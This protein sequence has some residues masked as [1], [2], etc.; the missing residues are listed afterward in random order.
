[1]TQQNNAEPLQKT[2][3]IA[4]VGRPNV[5]KSTLLN[6]LIGQKIS[7]VSRKAQ[8]TRHAITGILTQDE[9]QFIFVDTP[10]FQTHHRNALNQAMNRS[11]EQTLQSVDLVLF[12][13]EA[14]RFTD[15]DR[16]VLERISSQS[17]VILVINKLDHVDDK[18]KLLPFLEKMNGEF[19]FVA[20]VPISA[21]GGTNLDSL[22]EAA[23]QCL[24][25]TPWIFAEDE[26]TDKNE[27]FLA[28]EFIREK[29]FRLMGDEIPYGAT[30]EIEKFEEQGT[31]RRIF[32]AIIVAREN[33]KAMIIGQGGERLK[34]I[35]SE[36]RIEM[37]K[38]FGSKIYL[39][40]WVKVKSGWADDVRALKSLGYD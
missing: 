17:K 31:L 7:I 12:V 27:R 37:E 33:H 34:R 25:N 13:I 23:K 11:V 10:G 30:V 24:P 1:M 21:A 4:I 36:A 2:G 28:A 6:R 19:P 9:Y 39:E 8:T 16:Q 22:L 29:L 40:V 14:Q 32:A 15:D 26:I 18:N 3:Y 20:M 35:S 38:L 5:G